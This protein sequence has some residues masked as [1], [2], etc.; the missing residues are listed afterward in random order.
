MELE[1]NLGSAIRRRRL[2]LGLSQTEVAERLGAEM[3]QSDISRI[4]R[5]RA[6]SPRPQLLMS[7]AR[8]LDISIVDLMA[9]AGW[10]RPD[11]RDHY[12]AVGTGS[13]PAN[14]S[15]AKD[16]ETQQADPALPL[17]IVA[18]REVMSAEALVGLLTEHA[19]QTAVAF[20]GSTLLELVAT[21]H[22]V[23]VVVEHPL[24]SLD[25]ADLA[26]AIWQQRLDTVIIVTG[27]Q[28]PE[29]PPDAYF[30]PKPLDFYALWR[31]LESSGCV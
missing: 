5:G 11:E 31:V 10:L 23:A 9:D 17:V 18:D 24:P 12:A 27:I 25:L 26:A 7:L 16:A 3:Q 20:E 6:R 8:V 19:L 22:P 30:L 4:E 29:L 15:F 28:A 13:R 2:E 14:A 1:R 21:R